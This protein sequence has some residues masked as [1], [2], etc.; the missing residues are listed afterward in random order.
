M[1]A[2]TENRLTELAEKGPGG[3]WTAAQIEL[4]KSMCVPKE[5]TDDE[6]MVMLY[7]AEKY[8]LDPLVKQIYMQKFKDRKT[9]SWNPATVMVSYAGMQEIANRDDMLDGL[10][11]EPFFLPDGKTVLGAKSV[12][13]KKGHNHPFKTTVYFNEYAQ[14]YSDGNLMGLW[15]TKPI[16]M[17]CKVANAQN[18][19]QAF[20]LGKL[21]IEEEMAQ[22]EPV[23]TPSSRQL[24]EAPSPPAT[25]TEVIEPNPSNEIAARLDDAEAI[26]EKTAIKTIYD[27]RGT[28]LE[29]SEQQCADGLHALIGAGSI[30]Q[31]A[32]ILGVG[33][34]G[35]IIKA[36]FPDAMPPRTKGGPAQQY[37]ALLHYV[38][39][40]K[41]RLDQHLTERQEAI[42]KFAEEL[43]R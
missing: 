41:K 20:S 34:F 13:W 27:T 12:L 1:A 43:S 36:N 37:S 6:F 25:A 39:D 32:A 42:D 31:A 18:L 30:P 14:K 38:Y 4:I 26:F 28:W 23:I 22:A 5:A 3:I 35:D 7:M 9:G 29:I 15:A 40:Y 24:E 8:G 17:I 33:K 11:A 21:Y 10:E 2:K 19:R 16:T